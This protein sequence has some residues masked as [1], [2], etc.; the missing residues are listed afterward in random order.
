MKQRKKH[1]RHRILN[2]AETSGS[3]VAQHLRSDPHSLL[4]SNL[5]GAENRTF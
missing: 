1:I 2:E 3:H 5:L 4:S